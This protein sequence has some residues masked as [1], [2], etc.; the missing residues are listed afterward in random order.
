MNESKLDQETPETEQEREARLNFNK[1]VRDAQSMI[2]PVTV[3][4]LNKRNLSPVAVALATGL[5]MANLIVAVVM[6]SDL[7]EEAID[8]HIDS[9]M[10]DV[11]DQAKR[12]MAIAKKV[13][14]MINAGDVDAAV[15]EANAIIEK[16]KAP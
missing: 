14:A 10:K 15:A 7:P 1:Q 12:G 5:T 4:A 6:G 13:G 3:E 11:R 16:A 8:D 2:F 9:I